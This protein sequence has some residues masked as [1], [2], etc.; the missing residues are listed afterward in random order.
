MSKYDKSLTEV[1]KWKENV[2]QDVKGL[3]S[4]EMIGKIEH[5]ADKIL[6]EHSIELETIPPKEDRRK[7]G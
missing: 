6:K 3:T 5:D 2:Y 4:K 1:W 7:I